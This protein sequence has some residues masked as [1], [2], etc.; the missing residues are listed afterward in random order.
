MCNVK[1]LY[2]EKKVKLIS[3]FEII[4]FGI[5]ADIVNILAP[6]CLL[7]RYK[8]IVYKFHEYHGYF[9]SRKL[10]IFLATY[11]RF[12]GM[13]VKEILGF[14]NPWFRNCC[15]INLVLSFDF[16]EILKHIGFIHSA[17]INI[18]CNIPELIFFIHSL[19]INCYLLMSIN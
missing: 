8:R 14:L 12:H 11:L 15:F 3:N 5:I 10:W 13:L 19:F 7:R 17:D 4:S 2:L 1:R 9:S 6:R 16:S 18:Y